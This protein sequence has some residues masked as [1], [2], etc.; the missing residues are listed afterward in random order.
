MDDEWK[1]TRL[2]M[3]EYLINLTKAMTK[4]EI[5]EILQRTEHK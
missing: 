5:S 3:S 4:K 1:A 2:M